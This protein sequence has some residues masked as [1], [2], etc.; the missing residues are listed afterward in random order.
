MLNDKSKIRYTRQI[1]I[2]NWGEAI[3]LKLQNSK[4]F[5]AGAGGLGSPVILYLASAGIGTI[6]ICDN[7]TLQ[8]HNLNRQIIHRESFID[9]N[10]SESAVQSVQSYNSDIT[11]LGFNETITND[12]VSELIKDCDIIVDCLDNFKTRHILNKTAIDLKKPL[13]HG[14]I[15]EFNGQLSFIHYPHTPCLGCFLPQKDSPRKPN[16][17]GSTAGIIGSM[18]ASEVIKYL[19]GIGDLLKNRILFW[20]GMRMTSHTIVVKPDKN[21]K[22]CSTLRS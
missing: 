15:E 22:I 4:V 16:V 8:L 17:V 9:K 21:C 19:T 20:D 7:D 6:H 2:K 1:P 12:N 10:K 11:I 13:V 3:Q 5:I 14:G 18:Q